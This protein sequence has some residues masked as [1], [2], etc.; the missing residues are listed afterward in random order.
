MLDW[1][2]IDPVFDDLFM[3]ESVADG[4][5]VA[6]VWTEGDERDSFGQRI[7]AT[8]DG[9]TW[10]ELTFP[11]GLFPQA[12]NVSAGRWVV[13][14]RYPDVD[15]PGVG[16]DRVFFSDD[17]GVT[18][19]EMALDVTSDPASPYTSERWGVSQLLISGERVVLVMSGYESLDGQALL[20]DLGRLPAG[21][22][23]AFA[24]PQPDGVH[25]TLVDADAL[26]NFVAIAHFPTLTAF[27]L[28]WNYGH[29]D[30]EDWPERTHDALVLRY[31]EIGFTREETLDMSVPRDSPLHHI[32]S[33]DGVTA[34]LVASYEGWGVSGTAT[35]EGFV[36]TLITGPAATPGT[37]VLTSP[38]G[39]AWSEAVSLG[40]GYRRGTVSSD[41]TI[42]WATSDVGGSFDVQRARPGETPVRAAT[43]RGL[44][45]PMNPVAGPAGVAIIATASPDGS[46]RIGERDYDGRVA[47]NGYEL[48]YD[49]TEG[50]LTLWD[51]TEGTV[52]S[53]FGPEELQSSTLPDGVRLIDEDQSPTI[54][55]EGPDTGADLVTFTEEDMAS[56]I[57]VTA[58]ELEAASSGGSEWPEQRVGWSADGTTWGWES[59]A[60]AFGTDDGDISVEFAVG[61]D[62]VIARVAEF[63]PPDASGSVDYG[64]VLPTRWFLAR[65]P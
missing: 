56:L 27:R 32:F 47:S 38:D 13:A 65:V 60:D 63:H 64:D 25:F 23:V 36:L 45:Y 39:V 55:F 8:Q 35:E 22:E 2:E 21:K 57:G 37:T 31:D 12:I 40:P 16:A 28:A 53:V 11:E 3:L 61:G 51:L 49:K 52:V 10:A 20:E 29:F 33:G 34:E 48:R 6:R 14:G 18:W 43:F 5:V 26:R 58:A 17:R 24:S 19:T 9:T 59:L 1:V 62:F 44:Q 42:W 4:R 54:V 46:P 50:S 30:E 7:V 41:G 15:R